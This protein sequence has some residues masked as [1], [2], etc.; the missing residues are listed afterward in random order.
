VG[1]HHIALGYLDERD[2]LPYADSAAGLSVALARARALLHV[3]REAEAAQSAEKALAMV[4]AAPKLARFIP[5][6]MDRAALYNLAAGR[7]DQ[8]L[9][10]YD[11]ALPGIEA[12]PRDEQGLRNRLVMRLA[13]CAAA[14]GADKPQR[15]LED[16]D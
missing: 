12:S 6:V 1:N 13:R 5:L 2:K 9:A 3:N 7:F 4:E 8:A 10:L 16:L 14:L 11:R 15:T